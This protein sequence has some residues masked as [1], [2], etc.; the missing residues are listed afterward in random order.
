[1]Q[2][3]PLPDR[4]LSALITG[5]RFWSPLQTQLPTLLQTGTEHST[6]GRNQPQRLGG[7]CEAAQALRHCIS[8]AGT[9]IGTNAHTN[10]LTQ[11]IVQSATQ[12]EG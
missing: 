7:C 11:S 3:E 9:V 6:V 1:M 2:L 12:N 5:I 4:L 8:D 10:R